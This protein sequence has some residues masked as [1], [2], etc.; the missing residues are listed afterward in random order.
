VAEKY[1]SK[2]DRADKII[3]TAKI[4]GNYEKDNFDL[5]MRDLSSGIRM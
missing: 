5:D 4:R 1:I 3:S 2:Y